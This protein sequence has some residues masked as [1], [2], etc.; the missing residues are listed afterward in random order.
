[1]GHCHCEGCHNEYTKIAAV[2]DVGACQRECQ[3]DTKCKMAMFAESLGEC[4]L[5][6]HG[7]LLMVDASA[8]MF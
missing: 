7:A 2:I 6:D 1:M 8:P 5:Y 3:N 4:S